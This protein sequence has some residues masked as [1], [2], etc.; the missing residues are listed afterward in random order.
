MF[1]SCTEGFVGHATVKPKKGCASSG[2]LG[3]RF[4]LDFAFRVWVGSNGHQ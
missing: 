2:H 1:F 3:R 4:G